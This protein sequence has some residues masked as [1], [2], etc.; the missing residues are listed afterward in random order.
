[1]ISEISETDSDDKFVSMKCNSERRWWST[2]HFYTKFIGGKFFGYA[3]N[4]TCESYL[5]KSDQSSIDVIPWKTIP[6]V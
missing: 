4:K 3:R 1:M 2:F 6:L 5:E